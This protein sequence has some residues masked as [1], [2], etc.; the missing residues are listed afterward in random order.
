MTKKLIQK[1]H[2]HIW[3]TDE[4]CKHCSFQE[5]FCSVEGCDKYQSRNEEYND[6]KRNTPWEDN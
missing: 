3:V 5:R 2:R 4:P 1:K 6:R